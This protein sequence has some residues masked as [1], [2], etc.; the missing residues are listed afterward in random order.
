MDEVGHP[1]VKKLRGFPWMLTKYLWGDLQ[2]MGDGLPAG[3]GV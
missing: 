2:E 3:R 1:W